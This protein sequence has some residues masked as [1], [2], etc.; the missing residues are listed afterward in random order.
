MNHLPFLFC[1]NNII[2]VITIS[3]RSF[4]RQIYLKSLLLWDRSQ[5]EAPA[6][7]VLSQ[8]RA[9]VSWTADCRTN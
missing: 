6:C 3:T 9:N 8:K 4:S 2:Y 5:Q 1:Q 7:H